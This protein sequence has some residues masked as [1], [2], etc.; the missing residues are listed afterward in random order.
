M[1]Q[2]TPET[3]LFDGHFLF[4]PHPDET[5]VDKLGHGGNAFCVS[6]LAT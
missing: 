6:R 5:T 1:Q 3:G 2:K 4:P